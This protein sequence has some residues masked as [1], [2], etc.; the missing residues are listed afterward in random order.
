M[1]E[2]IFK[3]TFEQG[4]R[5]ITFEGPKEFV[6]EQIARFVTESA[7]SKLQGKQARQDG[8]AGGA[9]LLSSSERE[10]IATKSPRGHHEIIAVLAFCLA[11]AGI[12]EFGEEDVKRAYIR[13]G[14]R[15]P[16]VLGQALRDAKNK[17]D[18]IEVGSKRGTYRLS[19]HGERTVRFDLPRT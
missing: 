6:E 18:Y 10:L 9:E 2:K 11:E 14:V 16:K 5:K 15:P 4:D 8:Q 12:A 13:A 19:A 17:F 7:A 3:G 1:G